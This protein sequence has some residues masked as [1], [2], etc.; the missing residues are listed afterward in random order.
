MELT[1]SQLVVFPLRI[2]VMSFWAK[3]ILTSLLVGSQ[4]FIAGG[5][6]LLHAL[7]AQVADHRCE[8]HSPRVDSA[9]S[10]VGHE[11]AHCDDRGRSDRTSPPGLKSQFRVQD[12]LSSDNLADCV[13]CR[14][15]SQVIAAG[16]SGTLDGRMAI[17]S[18]ASFSN[19]RRP[20]LGVSSMH[21][22]RGPP[23]C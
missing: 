22:G 20:I 6:H 13:F 11:H 15:L 10:H 21:S 12:S 14:V 19:E 23:S 5:P 16:S 8:F 3:L 9:H 4:C 7:A 18:R 2:P 17:P 1:S